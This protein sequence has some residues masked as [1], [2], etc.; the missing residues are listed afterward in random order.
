MEFTMN[1][2]GSFC[3]RRLAPVL[4]ACVCFLA[5]AAPASAQFETRAFNAFPEGAYS[6]AVGDFNHDGKLD[7]VM[8]V[9]AGFAVALGNGDG[10]F[11]PAVTYPT[12]L[13]R[14]LAVADFNHD[15]NLDIVT[16]DGDQPGTVSVYLG[17]GDG[18]FKMPPVVSRTTEPNAFVAVGDFNGDGKPDVVVIDPPYI[19]VLLGNGDGTLQP[20]SDN[21]S[22]VAAG[23]LAVADFNNDHKLDVI[24]AGS[25][26]STYS[27][28]VLLGN[29]NG[30]LQNAIT[31][32]LQYV[33]AT[34]AAGDLNGDGNVDAILGY[35]LG[36][37][38]V[39]LG[40]GDGTLQAAVNYSTT[41]LGNGE[42]IV[43]DL[44]LDG[45]LD[46]VV[47]SGIGLNGVAGIDV[48]WGHGDG[49]LEPA[50]FFASG[51][52]GLPAVGD[53]NGD[54]LP[55]LTFGNVFHGAITMLNT[56]TASFFPTERLTFPTQL[57]NT[58]SA[59]QVVT[60]KN[61]G[62]SAMS[63]SSVKVSEG[64]R[65]SNSCGDSVAAGA[66]CSISALFQPSA[67][68]S[69]TGLITIVDSASSRPQFIE[70]VG[71]A[72]LLRV[73]PS[74]LNFGGQRVGTKSKTQIVT[75]TNA[76]STAVQV[77]A[78]SVGGHDLNDFSETNT[79]T[80]QTLQ[81]GA[82]CIASVTFDPTRTGSRSAGLYFILS[83][84]SISPAPVNLSGNGT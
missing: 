61:S 43:A 7:V 17:N 35:D 49:T 29:G 4:V 71:T 72:T 33:P 28:G 19:S 30:T 26:G 69:Y 67:A 60:L 76:G 21:G 42:V 58:R 20:P 81:P 82:N 23:W 54:H 50:Q 18:T 1:L 38:A 34:V 37:V 13:A 84:G 14:S 73:S 3:S 53:L 41:G 51:V 16:A 74:S 45:R 52:S 44:N 47:P 6:I 80:A 40:N 25:F 8:T 27:I 65:E 22:F 75:A 55:D 68:S 78:V 57:I 2:S 83:V 56:G 10:T 12:K 11:L 70:L 77:S 48:F 63:I 36:G 31:E 59:E 24:S 46:V 39:L 79:C 32:P 9:N 15:G 62:T 64:F 5:I 66:Q